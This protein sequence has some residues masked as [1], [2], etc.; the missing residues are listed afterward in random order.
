[1]I[2]GAGVAGSS[3]VADGPAAGAAG[4]GLAVGMTDVAGAALV[5]GIAVGTVSTF[6]CPPQALKRAALAK[7][8][9]AS[10]NVL[11]IVIALSDTHTDPPALLR[12][13][14]PSELPN[15]RMSSRYGLWGWAATLASH[16]MREVLRYKGG[17]SNGPRFCEGQRRNQLSG[18]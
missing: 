15:E 18:A 16:C 2:S 11:I 8:Q 12:L 9:I 10:V 4:A 6:C 13:S 3:D 1:M 14:M 17:A 5:A 7:A